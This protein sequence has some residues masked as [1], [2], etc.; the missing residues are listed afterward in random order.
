M[1]GF[2]YVLRGRNSV[3]IKIHRNLTILEVSDEGLLKELEL[4]TDLNR[5]IVHW[6][7]STIFVI[8]HRKS[9]EFINKLV[10]LGYIPKVIEI[11][12]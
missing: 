4:R 6:I 1:G 10:K 8:D 7:S 11:G 5:F 9:D 3:M 12:S 2:Y